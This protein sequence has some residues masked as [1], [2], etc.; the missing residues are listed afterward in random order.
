MERRFLDEPVTQCVKNLGKALVSVHVH[1]FGIGNKIGVGDE[2]VCEE[3]PSR[4]QS[5]CEAS[6][7]QLTPHGLGLP[8]FGSPP[9]RNHV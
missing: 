6:K 1:M 7:C 2:E 3:A 9:G 4:A 5:F 8:L